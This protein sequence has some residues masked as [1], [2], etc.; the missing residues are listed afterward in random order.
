LVARRRRG[1]RARLR[2]GLLG[3]QAQGRELVF[4]VPEGDQHLLAVVGQRDVELR[5]RVLHTGFAAAAVEDRQRQQR[6]DA[7][8]PGRPP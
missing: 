7:P 6:A 2:F 3:Q 5:L 1:H 8:G 4:H